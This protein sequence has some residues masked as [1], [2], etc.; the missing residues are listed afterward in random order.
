MLHEGLLYRIEFPDSV[1]FGGGSGGRR[2][3]IKPFEAGS[4]PPLFLLQTK[5]TDGSPE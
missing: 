3:S 2:E 4:P 5:A 1:D